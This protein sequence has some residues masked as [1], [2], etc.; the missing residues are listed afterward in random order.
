MI[1]IDSHLD[2]AMN[3]FYL[4]RDLRKS[5]AGIREDEAEMTEK[6]RGNNTL[7]F[8]EMRRTEMA[9]C[10]CTMIAR[11]KSGRKDFIDVRTQEIA[12][13]HAQGELAF[14]REMERQGDIRMITNWPQLD[15]HMKEWKAD[16][17]T[18]PLG[19]VLTMEGADPIVDLDQLGLWWNDGLRALSLAHYGPSEYAHGTQAIGGLTER[20]K[21]LLEE[22]NET[23]LVLDVTHLNDQSFWE[24]VEIFSATDELDARIVVMQG[25]GHGLKPKDAFKPPVAEELGVKGRAENWWNRVVEA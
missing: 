13:A 1:V 23:S 22:M 6:G 4:D 24:A 3:A 14:Y 19:M 9:L 5:V 25:A 7:S 21:A 15:A 11:T 20:G 16:P 2:I 12:Y 17:E 18:T 10:F 8:P